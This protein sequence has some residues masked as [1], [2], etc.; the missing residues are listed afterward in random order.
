[1]ITGKHPFEKG[2]KNEKDVNKNIINLKFDIPKIPDLSGISFIQKTLCLKNERLDAVEAVK[3]DYITCKVQKALSS[4]NW[5][6]AVIENK[7]NKYFYNHHS[8]YQILPGIDFDGSF[9]GKTEST[10]KTIQKLPKAAAQVTF[11]LHLKL[12][13]ELSI[14]RYFRLIVTRMAVSQTCCKENWR[15]CQVLK[16]VDSLRSIVAYTSF[17]ANATTALKPFSKKEEK[18]DAESGLYS[19]L[20]AISSGLINFI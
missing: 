20:N 4:Y 5:A 6:P 3:H 12:E 16:I 17:S 1:M 11:F 13:N 8:F 7:N 10:L 14:F 18:T 15:R 9:W 2:A 19:L